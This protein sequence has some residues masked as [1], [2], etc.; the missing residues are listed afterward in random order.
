MCPPSPAQ[1]RIPWAI[2]P[3]AGSAGVSGFPTTFAAPRLSRRH[4]HGHRLDDH[5]RR[6]RLQLHRTA[7]RSVPGKG[8][9]FGRPG[10][11]LPSRVADRRGAPSV[12]VMADQD[13]SQRLLARRKRSRH[14]RQ[15]HH[16]DNA[17]QPCAQLCDRHRNLRLSADCAGPETAHHRWYEGSPHLSMYVANAPPAFSRFRDY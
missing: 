10:D 2:A 3:G 15:Y 1:G 6:R 8:V 16:D 7:D 17:P 4:Q 12:T 9:G 5:G 13:Q 11:D 14:H